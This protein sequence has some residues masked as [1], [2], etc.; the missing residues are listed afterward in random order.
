MFDGK[1][2][3]Y[4]S[5]VATE[6]AVANVKRKPNSISATPSWPLFPGNPVIRASNETDWPPFDFALSGKPKGYSVDMLNL[7]AD[8]AGL[9]VEYVNGYSWEGLV[10][11]FRKG[12]LD[13][14]HSLLRNAERENMGVFTRGYLPMPQAFAVKDGTPLPALHH[15]TR[16]QDR[17]HTQGVEHGLLPEGI[18]PGGEAAAG[19]FAPRRH[20]GPYPRARACATLDSEP[21]LR[22]LAEAYF[23][24]GLRIGGHPPELNGRGDQNL[25]FLVRP[26]KAPL[27]SILN[28]ALSMVTPEERAPSR[29]QMVRR[30]HC[31]R[32]YGGQR[33]GYPH[34]QLLELAKTAGPEGDLRL[35]DIKGRPYFGYVARIESIYGLDEFLGLLV[36]VKEI[37]KP[38]MK[39]VHYSLLMTL[40]LLLFLTPVVWY[41]ATIIVRPINALA[42]G[43]RKK[44][45]SGAT[46]M[47]ALFQ[48]TS[49]KSSGCPVPWSPWPRPSRSTR[50]R[51]GSSWILSS[52]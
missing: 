18:P 33:N 19:R 49:L 38:Y 45:N 44:S 43:K 30:R 11:L 8:M 47:C 16:G 25:H 5:A 31:G 32:G 14:L 13:L 52:N 37:L 26:E 4:R 29:R 50:N 2:Q 6:H 1:R 10:E 21:V 23:L 22:Y 20:A 15:R 7:L 17:G 28:K 12:D 48:A 41:C 34:P 40:G 46:T 27:A 36:P 51:N 35:M 39:K 24:D 9:R 42:L 3:H